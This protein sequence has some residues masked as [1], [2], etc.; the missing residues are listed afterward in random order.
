MR[1]QWSRKI[2]ASFVVTGLTLVAAATWTG[3]SAQSPPRTLPPSIPATAPASIPAAVAPVGYTAP[4]RPAIDAFRDTESTPALSRQTLQSMQRGM[5]WLSRMNQPNGMFLPGYIPA[6]NRPLEED[7]LVRQIQA[8]VALAQSATFAGDGRAQV[9]AVQSIMTLMLQTSVDP[10]NADV[11]IPVYPSMVCNRL[12]AA[13][14]MVIAISELAEPQADLIKQAEELCQFIRSRQLGD[15]SLQHLDAPDATGKVDPEGVNLWPGLA[16]AAVARSQRL[17]NVPWKTDFL[18]KA[19]RAYRPMLKAS[20]SADLACSM[21]YGFGEAFANVRDSEFADAVCD[22]ADHLVRCQL[23]RPESHSPAILGGFLLG[24]HSESARR[25]IPD[26]R[27]AEAVRGLAMAC[28][29]I[30]NMASPDTDRYERCRHAM[31]MGMEYVARLQFT[32]ENTQ[33]FGQAYRAMLVGGVHLSHQDGDLRIDS[34]ATAVGA[35]V[36]YFR[37]G[38]AK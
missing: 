3:L 17:A 23:N 15:G 30:R 8:T 33:H 25:G 38:A 7:H 32:D 13:A 35:M 12:G 26:Y 6:L 5:S 16:V 11:R 21:S 9:R 37:S 28:R 10:A 4:A 20:S 1:I 22:A 31:S 27:S 24:G 18:R 34:T 19:V 14:L 29:V 2:A 36:E